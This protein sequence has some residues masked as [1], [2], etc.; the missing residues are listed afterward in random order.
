MIGVVVPAHNEEALIAR[1]LLALKTAAAH[2]GLFGETVEILVVL[3]ACDDGTGE[4]VRA[5]GV[6]GLV[7]GHRNVGAARAEGAM[8][9]IARGARWLAFTDA[10]SIVDPGWLAHQL[11]LQSE[12]VC[13]VVQVEDWSDFSTEERL[14]YEAHY[15]DAEDHPHI[16]GANLGVSA[17]AYLRAGGFPPIRHRE[18]VALVGQLE[19]VGATIARTNTVRVTTSPRRVGRAPDGFAGFMS[20]LPARA[21]AMAHLLLPMAPGLKT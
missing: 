6:H 7:V 13:G 2:P 12:A 10:D 9:L 8:V 21:E 14:A 3:D 1:C 4:V 19:A 11:A 20:R 16:H 17:T 18:D 5:L 15:V